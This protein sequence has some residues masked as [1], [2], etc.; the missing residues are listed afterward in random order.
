MKWLT[1]F[2][3]LPAA[4]AQELFLSSS[5]ALGPTV[6]LRGGVDMPTVSLGSGGSCHP[7]P[8]GSEDQCG[9]YKNTLLAIGNGYRGFHT[10]LDY[11]NQ[12]GLGAAVKAS[13]LPRESLFLMSMVPTYLMGYNETLASVEASLQQMQLDYLDLVMVHHRAGGAHEYPL[14]I[15]SMKAFPDDWAR[16]GS[17]LNNATSGQ[18]T[19]QLPACALRD[20]GWQAC[21]D[22][23]W[24]ALVELK[25]SG[26]IRAIGVSNWMVA[27][28]ER[29]ARL[30]Q[31]L[32][33]VNQVE[34]HIGW[35]DAELLDWCRAH[36]VAL[37]AATPT[38]RSMPALVVP[39]ADPTISALARKYEKLPSQISLRFLVEKGIASIPNSES[40]EHQQQNLDIFDFALSPAEVLELGTLA[41][42]CR[43]CNQCFK[44]WGDPAQ[45]MCLNSTTGAM[46]HCP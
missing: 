19:W 18:A 21:Q 15:A 44:C 25:A 17:P 23:T 4:G 36:G 34:A 45:M 5:P 12:A 2:S 6:R 3:L 46:F 24:R 39:G 10:A 7:D 20:A 29:M 8:D 43:S 38:G 37:Q 13:G 42:P 28:L 35:W 11:C 32:P 26:K 22:E 27:N 33:A 14:R 30:G 41:I 1:I 40:S 9:N 16:A 31:E